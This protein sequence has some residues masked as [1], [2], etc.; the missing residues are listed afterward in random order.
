VADA[1]L[2]AATEAQWVSFDLTDLVAEWVDGSRR[3]SGVLLRLGND[4]EDYGSS[5]PSFPSSSFA[6]P[7]L[8]P[9]LE[10][11]YLRPR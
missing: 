11:T 1:E 4:D 9:Q 10:V 5:G 3:N 2:D 7:N 8:R 6:Q